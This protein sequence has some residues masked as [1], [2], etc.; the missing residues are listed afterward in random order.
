[1]VGPSGGH[2]IFERGWRMSSSVGARKQDRR[3]MVRMGVGRGVSLPT[4]FV[5]PRPFLNFVSGNSVIWC[6]LMYF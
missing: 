1:M 4:G 3:A 6:I 5:P 2:R